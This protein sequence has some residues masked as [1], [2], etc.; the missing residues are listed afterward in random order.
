MTFKTE[1]TGYLANHLARLYAILLNEQIKPLGISTAHFPILLEL[2]QQDGITQNDLVQ[3]GNLAQATIANTLNRM[4]RDGLITRVADKKDARVKHILLTKK[5]RS[6]ETK[7]IN[8]ARQVNQQSLS[9]L[10][11][12]EQ[13]QFNTLMQRV[14]IKQR[15][16]VEE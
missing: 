2:W 16:L 8:C 12:E 6:L 15:E 14:I 3:L 13:K 9:V 7:A 10:T 5:A 4:E 11:E 1:S